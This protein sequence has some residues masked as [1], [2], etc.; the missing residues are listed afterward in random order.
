MTLTKARLE[1]FTAFQ[2]LEVKFS[3]GV[4]ATIGV[5]GTGKTHLMKGLL[6]RVR[7]RQTARLLCREAGRSIYAIGRSPGSAGEASGREGGRSSRSTA[8][9]AETARRILN[10]NPKDRCR[11]SERRRPLAD[12]ALTG[13]YIPVKDTLA[14]APGFRSLYANAV[15]VLYQRKGR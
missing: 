3:P 14:N 6:C 9:R 7:C 1:S 10:P 5:N 2:Y 12:D 4:N 8:G 15:F 13:V 11:R